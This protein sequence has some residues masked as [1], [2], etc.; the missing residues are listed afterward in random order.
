MA[1]QKEITLYPGDA[2]PKDIILRELPVA[3]ASTTTIWLVEGD[4]TPNNI[5]LGDPTVQPS[6]GGFPT[7]YEFKKH[8]R[9]SGTMTDCEVAS[10]DGVT[11]IGGQPR[12]YKGG[13]TYADYL[14]VTGDAN[15]SPVR[16]RTSS[17]TYSV[18]LK[19]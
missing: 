1:D 5:I 7:Q 11:G 19:T 10:G 17:G 14:V 15:A 2:T 16:V 6:G 12:T 18:R 13:V 8:R 4:A 9:T 3:S